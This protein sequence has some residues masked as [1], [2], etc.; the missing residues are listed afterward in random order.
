MNII[1]VF[2]F[3]CFNIYYFIMKI[4][5]KKFGLYY[6]YDKILIIVYKWNLKFNIIIKI[7]Y[8]WLINELRR[9]FYLC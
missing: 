4:V 7:V 1:Y 2:V 5:R 3:F 8:L 9:K 6:N